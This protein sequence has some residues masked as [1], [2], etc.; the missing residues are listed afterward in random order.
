[1]PT[2]AFLDRVARGNIF[3]HALPLNAE[4]ELMDVSLPI[5]AFLGG[6]ARGDIFWHAL[7]FNAELE[8]MDASLLAASVQLTHEIDAQLGLPPKITMSQVWHHS[9]PPASLSGPSSSK[10]VT[11]RILNVS[12]EGWV[13]VGKHNLICKGG[14]AERAGSMHACMNRLV[15]ISMAPVLVRQASPHSAVGRACVLYTSALQYLPLLAC[16]LTQQG[17]P[18]CAA[19]RAGVLA[20]RGASP[21]GP[22]HPGGHRGHKRR[23]RAAG[24]APQHPLHLARPPLRRAAAGHVAPRCWHLIL[25]TIEPAT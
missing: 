20:E 17:M 25:L 3:W 14:S 23:L 7:P 21:D 16:M 24:R 9:L 4:L 2:Q 10:S 19:R 12:A 15:F 6:V 1:M 8:L 13:V 18:G 5:Q 11:R 22:G